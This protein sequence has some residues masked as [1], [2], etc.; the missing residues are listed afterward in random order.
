M[1]AD[2]RAEVTTTHD[3]LEACDVFLSQSGNDQ[4]SYVACLH[5]LLLRVGA[6]KGNPQHRVKVFLDQHGLDAG[7]SSIRTPWRVVEHE[8]R[9]CRVGRQSC[10]PMQTSSALTIVLT[11]TWRIARCAEQQL[12][13]I[14]VITCITTTHQ[15]KYNACV[16]RNDQSLLDRVPTNVDAVRPLSVCCAQLWCHCHQGLRG[17]SAP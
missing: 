15:Y 2:L 7:I 11:V 6:G 9:N 12:Q 4:N 13:H 5:R 16:C 8:A 10:A 14:P 1:R 3:R 17:R